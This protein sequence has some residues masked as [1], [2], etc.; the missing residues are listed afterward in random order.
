MRIFDEKNPN[1]SIIFAHI[2]TLYHM[3]P[4]DESKCFHRT[5]IAETIKKSYPRAYFYGSTQND[6]FQGGAILYLQED[7]HI[8]FKIGL[9]G[10][11]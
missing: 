6:G 1:W 9:G 5:I 11:P 2:S 8:K 4:E 10:S 3:I 7:H